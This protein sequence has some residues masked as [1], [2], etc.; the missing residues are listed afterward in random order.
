MTDKTKG[1]LWLYLGGGAVGLINGL[2]GSGGGMIAVPML[3]K[4]GLPRRSRT[5]PP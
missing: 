5:P 4:I 3:R 1:R 2:L